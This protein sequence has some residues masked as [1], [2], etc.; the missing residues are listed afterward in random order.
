MPLSEEEL[1]NA[2]DYIYG[3]GYTGEDKEEYNDGLN[4]ERL[5]YWRAAPIGR[6]RSGLDR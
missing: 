2:A 3:N 6:N 4:Y 1:N 5:K